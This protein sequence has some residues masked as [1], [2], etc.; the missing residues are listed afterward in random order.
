MQS[1]GAIIDFRSVRQKPKYS[2]NSMMKQRAAGK[3]IHRKFSYF[4]RATCLWCMITLPYLVKSGKLIQKQIFST[5]EIFW[6]E[7]I[8][9]A[10]QYHLLDIRCSKCKGIDLHLHSHQQNVI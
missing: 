5:G 2:S 3:A 4:I 9:I 8:T 6:I 1:G 10:I 7:L